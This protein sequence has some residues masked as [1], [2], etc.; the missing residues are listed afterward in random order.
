M[1]TPYQYASN[2]P[3]AAIDIDGEEGG[4][5][6]TPNG[7]SGTPLSN[8]FDNT[9]GQKTWLKA[10]GTGLAMGGAVVTD[11]FLTKGVL[12][13]TLL[14]S[15]AIGAIQH[16]KASTPEGR[17]LQDKT[18][19][20]DLTQVGLLLGT[21]ELFGLIPRGFSALG[22]VKA[23]FTPEASA[24]MELAKKS[25]V[26]TEGGKVDVLNGTGE[27]SVNSKA[28]I[29]TVTINA[30]NESALVTG[31]IN[32][33]NNIIGFEDI[34]VINTK[35]GLGSIEKQGSIGFS[36]FSQLTREL[37][38]MT[39][40]GGYENGYIEFS[41][42]RPPGSKLPDTETRRIYFTQKSE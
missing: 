7:L 35:G 9:K 4:I 24:A 8:Y 36:S 14:T 2:T 10:M 12:T 39:K 15:A 1:L 21:G 27:L 13:R 28:G 22:K 23:P 26:L 33:K 37:G 20:E 16:N 18:A 11:I 32:I 5:P 3:I 30:G 29:F 31:N 42:L 40:A 34:E 17:S 41:R 38:E 6:M 19:K 25:K